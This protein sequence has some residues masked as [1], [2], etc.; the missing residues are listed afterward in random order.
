MARQ[1]LI[2]LLLCS[3][4]LMAQTQ[5]S[6]TAA[7]AKIKSGTFVPLYGS[8]KEP[9]AVHGFQLDKYP[10][11]NAEFLAFVKQNPQWQ[12]LKVKRL[13]ADQNYLRHWAS[14]ASIGAEAAKISNS[15]VINVSWFAAKAYCECQGKR[16]P[17]VNEDRKSVV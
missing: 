5:K 11:T 1:L 15:P 7:M 2:F 9:V 17:T 4:S 13:F 14:D 10:V 6:V 3:T 16:L 8:E 12:K